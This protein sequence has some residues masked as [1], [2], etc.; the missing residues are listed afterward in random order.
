MMASFAEHLNEFRRV[1][2]VH[3]IHGWD[4]RENWHCELHTFFMIRCGV[5][6][7]PDIY[8]NGK[9]EAVC[10]C[11]FLQSWDDTV[12]HVIFEMFGNCP[13]HRNILLMNNL[14]YGVK[15]FQGRMYCVVRG[16]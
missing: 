15:G 1:S 2:C 6:H 13:D 3:P 11:P 10:A 12:G 9:A 7:S 5:Q 4:S 16:W 8:L 14:A